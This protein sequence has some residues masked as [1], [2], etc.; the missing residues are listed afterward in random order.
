VIHSSLI[1]YSMTAWMGTFVST[2]S[3][4]FDRLMNSF[5]FSAWTE[6]KSR[7]MQTPLLLLS[8]LVLPLLLLNAGFASSET[9]LMST[10]LKVGSKVPEPLTLQNFAGQDIPLVN[11]NHPTYI[12]FLRHLA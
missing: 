11:D 6:W 1:H 5:A 8:Y 7:A 4:N 2:A 9:F 12:C 3:H 10:K